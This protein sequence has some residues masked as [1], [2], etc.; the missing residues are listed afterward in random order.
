LREEGRG[1]MIMSI[2]FIGKKLMVY[3]FGNQEIMHSYHANSSK[4]SSKG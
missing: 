4:D 1:K 2:L 3:F